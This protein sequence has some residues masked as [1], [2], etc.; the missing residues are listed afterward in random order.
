M[1][2]AAT[3]RWIRETIRDARGG[4]R[5]IPEQLRR[6]LEHAFRVDLTAVRVHDG[7]EADALARALDAD[8]FATGS[9]VFFA[10]GAFEP[11]TRR[12]RAV[13]AHEVCHL[14]QQAGGAGSG[15][16]AGRGFRVGPRR[17]EQEA[18]E[19]GRRFARRQPLGERCRPVRAIP[20]GP[21]PIGEVFVQCWDSFEHRLLGDMPQATLVAMVAGQGSQSDRDAAFGQAI[22]LM[23]F[24]GENAT[25]IE[26]ASQITAQCPYVRPLQL[27]GSGLWVTYGELNTLADYLADP[28]EIATTGAAVSCRS[29]RPRARPASTSSRTSGRTSGFPGR[30]R[31]C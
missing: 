29:C 2:G 6:E 17:W 27:P 20:V 18:H 16:T 9:D 1:L 13:I 5:P 28:T 3:V 14:L 24:L 26:S 15:P 10:A 11:G 22:D 25:S 31:C 8:A 12:G 23:Q 19:A 4:G 21:P 30:T 7:A